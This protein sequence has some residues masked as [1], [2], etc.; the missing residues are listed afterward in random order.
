MTRMGLSGERCVVIILRI[1]RIYTVI[2]ATC[3]VIHPT[4]PYSILCL[5]HAILRN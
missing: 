3:P 4:V 1:I 2:S 5:T